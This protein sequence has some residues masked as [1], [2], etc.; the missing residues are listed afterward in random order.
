MTLA[1]Y[2]S[3]RFL[4][5]VFQVAL[6]IV[7]VTGLLSMVENIRITEK[8][9]A[10][11]G[12]AALL[13]LWQVPAVLSEAFPLILML[14]ALVCFLGLSRSSELVIVRAA[15]VSAYRVLLWPVLIAVLI[16][17]VAVSGLNPIV[18]ATT[19]EA[20]DYKA[21]ITQRNLNILSFDEKS[22][23]LRQGDVT[24]QTVIQAD[25]ATPDGA[26]LFSVR[27]HMFDTDNQLVSRVEAETATL[28]DGIWTIAGNVR[29]W[30]LDL[31]TGV[32]L[33]A[34]EFLDGLGI[35][36]ELTRDRILESFA[37]PDTIPVWQLPGFIAQMERAGFS[38]TRHRVFLHSELARPALFAAMVLIGA[39]FSLRHVR[40][41]QV[42]V[43]ILF[44]VLA[45]FLL[46]FF[47]DV[48]ETMGA[49]GDIPI[50]L[51]AWAPPAAAILLAITLL[52]H[53]EEG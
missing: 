16:G 19:V 50:M 27:L 9:N 18:A 36:T 42:G 21:E 22:L 4:W 14:G 17:A 26:E 1:R 33:R 32:P 3:R 40:F 8:Y 15:G 2:I 45:G 46:Y 30:D 38:A 31:P 47:K 49:N 10:S 53:L 5:A 29:R 41:G 23:W 7:G 39:G 24:G 34:P 28:G 13:T 52:L 37:Q 20:E 35:P 48:T 43:M 12:Q 44:S 51:A 11:L 25:R 6:I